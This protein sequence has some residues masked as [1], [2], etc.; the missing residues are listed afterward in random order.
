[1]FPAVFELGWIEVIVL[2]IFKPEFVLPAVDPTI[3]SVIASKFII[4]NIF[5][6][7]WL[8]EFEIF[9][10]VIIGVGLTTLALIILTNLKYLSP[11][12]YPLVRNE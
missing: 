12:V 5:Q 7:N 3:F 4:E 9:L 11:K 10:Y 6:L 1:M 8:F 2:K